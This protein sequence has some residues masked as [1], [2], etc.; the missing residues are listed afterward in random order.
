MAGVTAEIP[1]LVPVELSAAV[2]EAAT[3]PALNTTQCWQAKSYFEDYA[4]FS[5]DDGLYRFVQLGGLGAAENE[6]FLSQFLVSS[7]EADVISVDESRG[8]Q[9]A[10]NLKKCF[11]D[12]Q[13]AQIALEGYRARI[14]D[15]ILDR[16]KRQLSQRHER[17]A[18]L[19]VAQ[20]DALHLRVWTGRPLGRDKMVEAG[21]AR[22]W[23]ITIDK[24]GATLPVVKGK[25]GV[26]GR[27][28]PRRHSYGDVYKGF[29]GL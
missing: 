28:S 11:E 15:R 27:I 17:L 14:S 1:Q 26:L 4:S 6:K 2:F 13:E 9:A 7:G 19:I 25:D 29:V 16:Q 18:S 21:F 8:L 22:V 5:S 12:D 20:R 3:L 23:G 24:S 10:E